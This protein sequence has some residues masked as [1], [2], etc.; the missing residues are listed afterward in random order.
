MIPDPILSA[1]DAVERDWTCNRFG[2][3]GEFLEVEPYPSFGVL[4][5]KARRIARH[6]IGDQVEKGIDS[7]LYIVG[8]HSFGKHLNPSPGFVDENVEI[9]PLIRQVGLIQECTDSSDDT[10]PFDDP[11]TLYACLFVVRVSTFEI[12]LGR[13]NRFFYI[14]ALLAQCIKTLLKVRAFGAD[15]I[16]L[17]F[18]HPERIGKIRGRPVVGVSRCASQSGQILSV[19]GVPV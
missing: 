18:E 10:C 1:S 13:N 19:S 15:R 14:A 8:A 12:T 4:Q 9:I 16:Q 2:Y 17:F 6:V 3:D 5:F 7:F 11:I